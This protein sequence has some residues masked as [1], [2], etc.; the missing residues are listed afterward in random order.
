MGDYSWNGSFRH[1]TP[2]FRDGK[3]TPSP[4]PVPRHDQ[5]HKFRF[6]PSHAATVDTG[7]RLWT[8]PDGSIAIRNVLALAVACS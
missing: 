8:R 7:L 4:P 2:G 3:P 1:L 5:A 6:K